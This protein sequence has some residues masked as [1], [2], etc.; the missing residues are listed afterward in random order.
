[1]LDLVT[2]TFTHMLVLKIFTT[3]QKKHFRESTLGFKVIHSRSHKGKPSL[4]YN[5]LTGKEE[6]KKG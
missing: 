1:M 2:G 6:A 4:K 3:Q 5:I